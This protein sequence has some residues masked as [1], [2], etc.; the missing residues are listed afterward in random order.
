MV[1]LIIMKSVLRINE[2]KY[3]HQVIFECVIKSK[4]IEWQKKDPRYVF[5]IEEIQIREFY[6]DMSSV[7]ANNVSYDT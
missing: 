2:E 7:V 6:K 5:C 4:K 1:I 3:E